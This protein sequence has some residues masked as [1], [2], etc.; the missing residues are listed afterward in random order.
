MLI[1]YVRGLQKEIFKKVHVSLS[2]TLSANDMLLCLSAHGKR[3]REEGCEMF[4]RSAL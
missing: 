1:E 3:A 4:R 2:G